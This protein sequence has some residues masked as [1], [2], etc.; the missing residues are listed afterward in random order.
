MSRVALTA[1]TPVW[2]LGAPLLE[3]PVWVARESALWFVDIKSRLIYRLVPATGERSSWQAPS[4]VGF[5]Q[6][7]SDGRFVAGLQSGLAMFDP[8]DGSFRTIC[9]PEPDFPGNRL[10]DAAV[11]PDGRLWFGTMDDAEAAAT[12]RI[13]RLERDGNCF[14]ATAPVAISNG[15]AVSADGR[16]L[17]HVDTLGGTI[18]AATIGL[19]GTL[20]DNRL[21]ATIPQEAGYPDGPALDAEGCLWIGLYNGYAARRYSPSGEWL[22]TVEF[23]VSAVTK[24]A[25]GGA[26]GCT[27][28]ATTAAKHLDAAGRVR[29][30]LAGA[31]FSFET[32]VPGA[33][34][35]LVSIH[36]ED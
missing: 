14:A 30:P 23:P 17:Y 35:H 28:Y 9:D 19:D 25:F 3:G 6:P 13:W 8:V 1:P 21:F 22:E 31:L 29:E 34:G 20:G 27:V 15:P 10:N 7:A 12:G 5:C 2:E 26:N 11:A 32:A 33:P 24:L 18:F 36:R 4:Q 16:T